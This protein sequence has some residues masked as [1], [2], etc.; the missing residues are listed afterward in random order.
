MIELLCDMHLDNIMF[1]PTETSCLTLQH[2]LQEFSSD[3][4]SR[5][6]KRIEDVTRLR[7]AQFTEDAGSMA[8]PIRPDSYIKMDNFYTLTVYEKGAEI[9]RLYRT[10]LGKDGFRCVSIS[11]PAHSLRGMM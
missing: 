11:R 9:V 7:T 1:T 10:L 5:P 6:V 2:A 8:H 3:M 4:N